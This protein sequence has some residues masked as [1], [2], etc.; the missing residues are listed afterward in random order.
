ME[1]VKRIEI[2]WKCV[3]TGEQANM[4]EDTELCKLLSTC[5][6]QNTMETVKDAQDEGLTQSVSQQCQFRLGVIG[7]LRL[8][9]WI[10][11]IHFVF[12]I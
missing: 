4:G 9:T 3:K 8:F 7:S 6:V 10:I 11:T 2:F 1:T 5:C 12:E